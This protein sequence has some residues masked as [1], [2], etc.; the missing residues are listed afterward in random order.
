MAISYTDNFGFALPDTGSSNWGAAINA[1]M[2][3]LDIE[4]KAA[5]SPLVSLINQEVLI[6]RLN[7]SI[8]LQHY[9]L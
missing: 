5:Q 6:S 1:A 7:G 3:R 9:Q 4:V 8:V 2:E